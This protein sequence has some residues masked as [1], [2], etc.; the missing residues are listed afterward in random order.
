MPEMISTLPEQLFVVLQKEKFL[1]LNTL[2]ADSGYPSVHAI[3][4]VYAKDPGTL[5][6]A[7]DARSRIVSNLQKN[8]HV[9]LSFIGAGSVHAIN[10]SARVVT[11]SLEDVP[12]KLACVDVDIESV[13]DAMFYGARI[14]TEPEYEKTYDK[15]AADKLDGQVFDAMKKPRHALCSQAFCYLIMICHI[16]G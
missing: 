7:V 14:V 1:I 5:R 9:S 11:D 3:S 12:F 8:P 16:I 6:F 15:R 4:W 10:G 13:H 2:D